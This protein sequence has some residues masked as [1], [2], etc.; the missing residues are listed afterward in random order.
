MTDNRYFLRL[1]CE[2]EIAD[3]LACDGKPE[4]RYAK[5]AYHYEGPRNA[6]QDPNRQKCLCEY[7]WAEYKYYWDAMWAEVP[8]G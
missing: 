2:E 6:I 3:A 4:F 7:H 5:T 1:T 8:R